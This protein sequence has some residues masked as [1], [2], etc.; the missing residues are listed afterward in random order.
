MSARYIFRMDDIT[1]TMHWGRFWALLSLFKN[2]GVK[3]LLGIVPDNKDPALDIQDP[4]PDFWETLRALRDHDLVDF[5][6]HGYQHLLEPRP[7]RAILGPELGIKEMSE[8]AG[9]TFEEQLRKITSGKEI[10]TQEG[11]PATYFMAPNHTFDHQT[12]RALAASGFT[13]ITDGISLFPF[14]MEGLRCVPQQV[15]NPR[16]V[17]CG[18]LT[19]CLH[20]N[21]L[22]PRDVKRLRLFLRRPYN[23]SRF[24]VEAQSFRPSRTQRLFNRGFERM[25]SLARSFTPRRRAV[26]HLAGEAI[27]GTETRHDSRQPQP[28]RLD[29]SRPLTQGC[30]PCLSQG[31]SSLL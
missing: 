14:F 17:P 12:L 15:W 13:A 16:W 8:F 4:A 26:N 5:A 29:S 23:F 7:G 27:E 6:Q 9:D 19:I 10:L 21:S 31:A 2:H 20:A 30:E 18:V 24:S 25:Y 1:P 3:P 11:I 28:S 22:T